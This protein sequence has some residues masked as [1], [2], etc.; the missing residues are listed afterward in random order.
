MSTERA[1]AVGRRIVQL[2]DESAVS[3]SESQAALAIASD[4]FTLSVREA[5]NAR[6]AAALREIE[7]PAPIARESA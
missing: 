2:L 7:T 6:L 1:I 5:D 3:V 4:L